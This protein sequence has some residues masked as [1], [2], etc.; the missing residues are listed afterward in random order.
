MRHDLH[1]PWE[2]VFVDDG[3]TDGTDRLLND[4]AAA[5]WIRVLRHEWNRGLGA[6]LRTGCATATARS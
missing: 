3:S 4:A 6:A 1:G 5:G 2:I